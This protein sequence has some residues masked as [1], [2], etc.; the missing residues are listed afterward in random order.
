MTKLR[1]TLDALRRN[2]TATDKVI[3]APL[4][5]EVGGYSGKKTRKT[6]EL[7]EPNLEVLGKHLT[8]LGA[9]LTDFLRKNHELL[10]KLMQ[11]P[12]SISTSDSVDFGAVPD[13]SLALIADLVG[14]D[15]DWVRLEMTGKQT[16]VILERYLDLM[17]WDLIAKTFTQAWQSWNAALGVAKGQMTPPK[18]LW[19][20]GR[21]SN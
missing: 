17:G 6:I 14:E 7:R 4:T 11:D 15:V 5:M 1:E 18:P 2:R 3:N 19:S 8:L 12:E 13:A 20:A 21:S 16:V 9:G 10:S